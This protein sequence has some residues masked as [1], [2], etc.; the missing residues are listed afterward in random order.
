MRFLFNKNLITMS[1]FLTFSILLIGCSNTSSK[2]SNEVTITKEMDQVISNTIMEHNKDALSQKDKQFEAHKIYGADE[3]NGLICIY[4]FALYEGYNKSTGTEIQSGH[5]YPA[6][7]KL[8]KEDNEYIVKEYKE[9]TDGSEYKESVKNM[10]PSKYSKKALKDTGDAS[11][12]KAELQKKV[13]K[14]VKETRN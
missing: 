9:P 12:L 13:E 6:L 11:D 4:L 8:A 1:V 5:S 14:W 2:A 10:F 3:K 7:I